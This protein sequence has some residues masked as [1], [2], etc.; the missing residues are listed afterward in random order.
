[1]IKALAGCF[2]LSLPSL[3][4]FAAL[5]RQ[6]NKLLEILT[7]LSSSVPLLNRALLLLAQ[8]PLLESPWLIMLLE[9]LSLVGSF[10]SIV[11]CE[12]GYCTLLEILPSFNSSTSLLNGTLPFPI[13]MGRLPLLAPRQLKTSLWLILL[14]EILPLI[15]R[16][17]CMMKTMPTPLLMSLPS[18][19]TEKSA[20]LGYLQT[21]SWES[22]PTGPCD[23]EWSMRR[24][25][26]SPVV[27]G[28]SHQR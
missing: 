21:G 28:Y 1:M 18:N 6:F 11:P 9:I 13:T 15:K 12:H 26:S 17:S 22:Y 4:L 20:H 24:F 25:S 7:F 27:I 5:T 19:P 16:L 8:F 2:L 10:S 14:A 3:L 23:K